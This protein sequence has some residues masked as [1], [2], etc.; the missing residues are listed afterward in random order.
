MHHHECVAPNVGTPFSRV[1]NS[2]PRQLLHSGRRSVI[3]GPAVVV[4][5]EE[6]Q[7]PVS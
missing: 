4:I 1:D 7:W 6:K 3:P 2:E 5:A